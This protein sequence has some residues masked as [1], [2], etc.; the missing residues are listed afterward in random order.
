MKKSKKTA[1]PD[2]DTLQEFQRFWDNH[3]L[4]NY[5]DKLKEVSF[6]VDI[7]SRRNLVAIE[8]D[9]L[10]KVRREAKAKGVTSESLVNIWLSEKV[11]KSAG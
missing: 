11:L 5:W 6:D 2:F 9:L 7:K 1:I 8:P 3:D 4:S 10:V